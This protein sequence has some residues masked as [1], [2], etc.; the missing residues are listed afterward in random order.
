[1]TRALRKWTAFTL[2]WSGWAFQRIGDGLLRFARWLHP[3]WQ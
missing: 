1:V 2:A 3:E